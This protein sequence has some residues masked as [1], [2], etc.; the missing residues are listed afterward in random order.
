MAMYTTAVYNPAIWKLDQVVIHWLYIF[1]LILSVIMLS[2]IGHFFETA[3]ADAESA[4]VLL[5]KKLTAMAS[6]DPVT[7]LVN[8]RT[9]MKRIE[10]EK[11]RVDKGDKTFALAMLDIDNFK[12]INDEYGH[13]GGDFVLTNLA[14]IIAMSIRKEDEVARWG[15]DEFLVLL[16]ETDLEGGRIAAEKIRLRI[17]RSPFVYRQMDI[18]VTIT[19]G[20]GSSDTSLGIGGTIRKADQA[21]YRGKQAGKNQVSVGDSLLFSVPDLDTK[22]TR[23]KKTN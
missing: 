18:P 9:I 8:R 7:N 4:L 22:P 15:G 14:Q 2:C 3:A 16:S 13:D 11:I 5:N 17:L 23:L 21:L 10:E 12:Q 19:V 1:N 6:T 20:V